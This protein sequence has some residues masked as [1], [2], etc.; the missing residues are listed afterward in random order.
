[1]NGDG[2][3]QIPSQVPQLGDDGEGLFVARVGE[4][5]PDRVGAS[6]NE[7]TKGIRVA[8]GRTHRA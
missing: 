6:L 7:G 1:M 2:A 5:D 8:A 3:S 4:V